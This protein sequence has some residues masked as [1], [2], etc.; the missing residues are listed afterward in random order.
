MTF[1]GK[2]LTAQYKIIVYKADLKSVTF[3]SDHNQ[4]TNENNSWDDGDALYEQPECRITPYQNNPL[5]HSK[6]QKLCLLVDID[7]QPDIMKFNLT[8]EGSGSHFNFFRKN[9]L[10][11]G[12]TCVLRFGQQ[13]ID[14]V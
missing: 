1:S 10:A 2:I 12:Q 8:G 5:T 11:Q 7:L 9:E 14:N 4:V 3:S 13:Q 6:N